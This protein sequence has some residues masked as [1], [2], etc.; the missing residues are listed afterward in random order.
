MWVGGR[1]ADVLVWS[2]AVLK[3]VLKKYNKKTKL[4]CC[5]ENINIDPPFVLKAPR[6]SVNIVNALFELCQYTA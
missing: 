4:L 2:A 1:L 3:N 5:K 6:K